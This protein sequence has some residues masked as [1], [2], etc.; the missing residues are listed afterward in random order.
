MKR[1][2]T[3]DFLLVLWTTDVHYK[4][5]NALVASSVFCLKALLTIANIILHLQYV[6]QNETNRFHLQLSP[7][8]VIFLS[9]FSSLL[10]YIVVV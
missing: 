5:C 6:R 7:K 2:Q 3:R 4:I 1:T 9:N 10:F 8:L